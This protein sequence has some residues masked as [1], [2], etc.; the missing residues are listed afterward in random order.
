MCF[1]NRKP[2]TNAENEDANRDGIR[3]KDGQA[4]EKVKVLFDQQLVSGTGP[5]V[6]SHNDHD[7][8]VDGPTTALTTVEPE[9]GGLTTDGPSSVTKSGAATDGPS[10]T[11]SGAATST[12]T[13]G[14]ETTVK[15]GATAKGSVAARSTSREGGKMPT[16]GQPNSGRAIVEVLDRVDTPQLSTTVDGDG[17]VGVGVV[18]GGRNFGSEPTAFSVLPDSG[19]DDERPCEC[20]NCCRRKP[21]RSTSSKRFIIYI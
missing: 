10:V 3:L 21:L 1:I 2:K 12:V 20:P 17:D 7:Q 4:A 5:E 13:K 8:R 19:R 18:A 11:K 6:T 14:G 9:I 16:T 15:S